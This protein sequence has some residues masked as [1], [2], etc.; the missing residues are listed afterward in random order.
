MKIKLDGEH[1]LMLLDDGSLKIFRNNPAKA[2][3]RQAR[4]YGFTDCVALMTLS[5][6]KLRAAIGAGQWISVDD[7][8]PAHGQA[9][10]VY[11]PRLGYE[12]NV[13]IARFY[14]RQGGVEACWMMDTAWSSARAYLSD[15]EITHWMPMPLGPD[16]KP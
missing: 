7:R 11:W 16:G 14:E 9:V 5:V 10:L 2:N 3:T 15:N 12:V 4:E 1:E 13:A 6:D 8:L